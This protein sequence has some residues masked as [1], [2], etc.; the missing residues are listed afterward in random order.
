MKTQPF[1]LKGLIIKYV[2]TVIMFA[3]IFASFS[4]LM[5]QLGVTGILATMIPMLVAVIGMTVLMKVIGA[6]IDKRFPPK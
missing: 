3:V 1:N 4:L 6:W 5:I 2:L